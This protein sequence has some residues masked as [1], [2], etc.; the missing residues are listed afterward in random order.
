M[1]ETEHLLVVLTEECTEVAERACKAARFGMTEVE[2]GQPDDNRRR[3]QKELGDLFATAELLGFTILEEDKAAKILKLKKYMDY[4]RSLGTIENR[5]GA[6]AVIAELLL[7]G[8]HD[9]PCTNEDD[10]YDSCDL[11]V[12]ASRKRREAARKFMGMPENNP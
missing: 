3:I 11:H 12:E 7:E 8:T 10:P 1:N 2:P 4:S 9:G 6:H 5:P